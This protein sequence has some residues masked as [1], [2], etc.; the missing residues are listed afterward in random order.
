MSFIKAATPSSLTPVSRSG[1]LDVL[2]IILCTCVLFCHF[3]PG[4]HSVAGDVGVQGF[5]ILSGYL[6][7][8]SFYRMGE[9]FDV[10]R[11]YVSRAK[12]LLPAY[13][14]A[15]VLPLLLTLVASSRSLVLPSANSPVFSIFE[16]VSRYNFAAWF[17]GCLF[18]FTFMAPF[19]WCLHRTRWGI[20]LFLSLTFAFTSFC[21]WYYNGSPRLRIGMCTYP[22]MH[23]W[24]FLAGMLAGR[25]VYNR[26]LPWSRTLQWVVCGCLCL[27]IAGFCLWLSLRFNAGKDIVNCYWVDVTLL[28]MLVPL[29]ALCDD[30]VAFAATRLSR[31]VVWLA[32][33]TYGVYLF[34]LPLLEWVKVSTG[35]LAG[36]GVPRWCLVGLAIVAAAVLADVVNRVCARCW[37]KR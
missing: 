8:T 17:M 35:H 15:F 1:K 6:L 25:M 21:F 4:Y 36:L 2:R 19:L 26:S 29:V 7:Q 16:F 32:S 28:L 20:P 37:G 22:Q 12:R 24:Q 34:H 11:F 14:I 27:L 13:L 30:G 3:Y 33:L 9:R 10:E 23:L 18:V 5:F 31:L